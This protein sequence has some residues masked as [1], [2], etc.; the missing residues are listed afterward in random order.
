MHLIEAIKTMKRA[1]GN[2]PPTLKELLKEVQHVSF[3]EKDIII[4]SF[5][6]MKITQMDHFVHLKYDNRKMFNMKWNKYLLEARAV[7]ID[8]VNNE[9]VM[10]PFDKFFELDEQP[11]SRLSDVK[12]A[13]EISDVPIEVTEK[14]DGSLI[15]ARFING[16]ILLSSSGALQGEHVDIAKTIL[17]KNVELSRFISDYN[18]YT[19]IMEMKNT[20]HPQLVK[21]NEDSLTIIGMRNMN[22]LHLLNRSEISNLAYKYNVTIASSYELSLDDMIEMMESPNSSHMEGYILKIGDLIVKMKTKNFI[23]ANRFMGDSARNFNMLIEAFNENRIDAIS[24]MISDDYRDSFT[25]GTR[26]ISRYI[27][28]KIELY[29]HMYSQFDPSLEKSIFVRQ[30]IEKFPGHKEGLISMKMGYFQSLGKED[31]KFLKQYADYFGCTT[32]IKY[33]ERV[34]K[35]VSEIEN[36]ITSGEIKTLKTFTSSQGQTIYIIHK[37]QFID[38]DAVRFH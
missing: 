13:M 7:V 18:D 9:T 10:Y 15:V 28:E 33:A 29:E 17:S 27:Q 21:Y 23:L 5:D 16:S 32:H 35:H 30:V 37:W 19:V 1:I 22:N 36:L 31:I 24:T 12:K 14:I 25:I 20:I 26:F 4:Q 3:P 38:L 2:P 11:G 6:A 8:Y 34:G